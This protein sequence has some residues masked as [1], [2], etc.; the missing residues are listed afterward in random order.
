[1]SELIWG[2]HW[3]MSSRKQIEELEPLVH[4]ELWLL[5]GSLFDE[6]SRSLLQQSPHSSFIIDCGVICFAQGDASML[7]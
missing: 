5:S 7:E 4:C 6:L 1:M 2:G 3:R